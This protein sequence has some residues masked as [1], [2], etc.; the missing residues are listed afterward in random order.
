MRWIELILDGTQWND[1]HAFVCNC[2]GFVNELVTK[3]S[4][5]NDLR[6]GVC[7]LFCSVK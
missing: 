1:E 5:T 3:S 7:W 6:H 2:G 4:P